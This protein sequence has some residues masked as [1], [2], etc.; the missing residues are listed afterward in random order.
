VTRNAELVRQWEVLRAI[1]GARCGISAA[2]LAA[3]CGVHPRTIRRDIDA[4]C[5]AGFPLYDEKANGTSMWRLRARP[6]QC[7]EQNGIG[8]GELAGLY[9]GRAVLASSGG[10][11]FEADVDRALM[12]IERT[13]PDRSRRLAADLP[14]ILNAKRTGRKKLDE[15]RVRDIAA[16]ALDAIVRERRVTMRYASASSGR[17]REYTIEPHRISCADGGLYLLAWVPDYDELRTFAIERI[18][19]L[20]LTDERFV[21]RPMP[22]EAFGN[23]LGVNSGPTERVEI[24]FDAS[25]A[26]YVRERQWHRSQEFEERDNGSLLLRLEICNDLPLQRWILGFGAH[27]HVVAPASLAQRIRHELEQ[28]RK[29]YAIARSSDRAIERGHRAIA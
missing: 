6:F 18:E 16:R 13:I 20:A 7:M 19:T 21:R 25:A 5:R 14:L 8:L 23:S 29:K 4:L 15:R 26:C 10:M 11:P 22:A 27:A 9:F 24:E 12:K 3:D 28:A 1:D 2:R 17:T